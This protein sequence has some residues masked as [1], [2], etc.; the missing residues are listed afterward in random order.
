MTKTTA[1]TVVVTGAAGFVGS[2]LVAALLRQHWQVVGFDNLTTGTRH[3]LDRARDQATFRFLEG[4]IRDAAAVQHAC[5]GCAVVIHLAAVTRVAESLQHPHKYAAINVMGTQTVLASAIHAGVER[6]VFASSAAVYGTPETT[7]IPEEAS[8]QPLSPY[9]RSKLTGEHLCQ[10]AAHE[11]GICAPQLRVFNI[12]GPRQ[13][14]DNEAGVVAIFLD[15]ARKGLPLIIYGDGNQTR[16]FIYIADVIDAFIQAATLEK[17]PSEP[18]NV[19]TGIPVSIREL[20]EAVHQHLPSGSKEIHFAPPRP[21]DI[22]H[23]VAQIDR[24]QDWL[25]FTPR[26]TLQEGLSTFCQDEDEDFES[27]D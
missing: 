17:V 13:P 7:P 1:G 27:K 19:G 3:N 16:D 5:D 22:Y 23:S 12:Y 21:G 2:H 8:T 24:L 6:V 18:I 14:T 10:S 25:H 9:G 26:Y 20:A 11:H 15:R 4:D